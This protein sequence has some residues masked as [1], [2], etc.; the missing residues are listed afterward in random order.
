MGRKLIVFLAAA[1]ITTMSAVAQTTPPAAEPAPQSSTTTTTT[2]TT[3]QNQQN[4]N[5]QVEPMDQTPTFKVNVVERTT[6]AVDYRD[7]GG[8][9][10][11]ALRGTEMMP[12]VTGDVKVTGHTGRLALNASVHH[13]K[14][15]RD[16]GLP[17]LTYVLWAITPQGRPANLGEVIPDDDGTAHLQITT[18]L[19]SFG[20]IVTAEPYFAVTRPSTAV[21]AEN[22][23]PNDVKGF[24][25]TINAKFDLM[26][27]GQYT[28]SIDP[29]TLPASG[30]DLRRVPLQLL[31]AR[32]A[33]A[34]AKATG[35]EQ[36]AADTLKKA[37]DMLARAED[38]YVRKQGTTP[39]GTAARSATQSAEDARLLTIN[40]KEEERAEA[41]RERMRQR[42]Q[43]AQSEAEAQTERA[44]LA[45]QEAADEA[46]RRERAEQE[47]EAAQRAAEEA[48]HARLAAEQA[49]QQS[50]QQL[51]AVQQQAQAA[52]QARAETERQA[53]EQ[54]Q[55]LVS[56][57]NSVLATKDTAR[58]VVSQ[59]SDVLFDV[60]KA[61]L[62]TDAQIRLAKISGI[63]LSYPD[64]K[65]EIDGYT[66]STGTLQ[67]NQT[68]SEKRAASV[69]DFLIS[70]GVPIDNVTAKGFGPE[71]PIAPNET[72]AGRKMNR[73]VELV[74]SGTA[75]GANN[76]PGATPSA[77]PQSGAIATPPPKD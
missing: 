56:Q 15:A 10:E 49:A 7:R 43:N 40:K 18:A 28:T 60:N 24:V 9:T 5:N 20:L 64:L 39:I 35:A 13:M 48:E 4:S 47:R 25:G 63:I 54:R 37:Q 3:I 14:P 1:A 42:I 8:S 61:T 12:S 67:W 68:L 11:V 74:L 30:A 46:A 65:L 29:A 16:L 55:R 72:A 34:I 33:V 73:R 32:D 19:S 17:Y 36:Y 44:R 41:A 31:E 22:I 45:K 77:T 23:I 50:Q 27:R 2:T 70:Q 21:V 62:K 58:G 53:A 69:R 71:N 76:A 26:D 59:M 75:I 51:A 6:Q 38:Y 57:L 66:D 52:E